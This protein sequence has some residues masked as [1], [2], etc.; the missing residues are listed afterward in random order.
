[1]DGEVA[2]S[3]ETRRIVTI[4]FADLV[5]STALGERLVES[6]EALAALGR[7]DEARALGVEALAQAE[8]AGAVGWVTA[9]RAELAEAGITVPEPPAR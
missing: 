2:S 5:G 9:R 7:G 6:A 3:G 1:V 8:K 4:L